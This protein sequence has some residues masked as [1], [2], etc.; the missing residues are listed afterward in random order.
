MGRGTNTTDQ[1][2]RGGGGANAIDTQDTR[3]CARSSVRQQ[4]EAPLEHQ[5]VHQ[6]RDSEPQTKEC[7]S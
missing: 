2:G 6:D 7:I 3:T 4:L 1:V 5:D